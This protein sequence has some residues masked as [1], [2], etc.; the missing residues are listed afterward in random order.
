MSSKIPERLLWA[1]ET[2]SISPD[3]SILE[4]GCGHGVAV[5]LIAEKLTTGKIIAIDRSESAI[6][7]AAQRNENHLAAG[8][9]E[10][11]LTSLHEVDFGETRFHKIFAVNVN[12]FWLTPAKELAVLKKLLT[13]DGILYLFYEPP[14]AGKAQEIVDKI[15]SNFQADGFVVQDTIIKPL[16]STLGVCI[17]TAPFPKGAK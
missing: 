2:L 8:K 1:A 6:R 17:T 3:D 10:F 16:S 13:T 4:I 7:A 11:H 15:S 5:S 14:H 12:V 9:A